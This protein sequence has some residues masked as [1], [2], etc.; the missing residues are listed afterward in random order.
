M[1]RWSLPAT[2]IEQSPG[3][4]LVSRIR[5]RIEGP[6]APVIFGASPVVLCWRWSATSRVETRAGH[7]VRTMRF[8]GYRRTVLIRT[9]T[10]HQ[11]AQLQYGLV[12]AA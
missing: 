10:A 12:G 7:L 2:V 1:D 9:I 8:W 4:Q 5:A 3:L 6:S 11:N